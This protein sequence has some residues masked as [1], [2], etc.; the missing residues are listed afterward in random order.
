MLREKHLKNSPLGRALALL[1]NI[2]LGSKGLSWT[3]TSEKK[4]NNQCRQ[5]DETCFFVI[6]ATAK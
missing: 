2:K 1:A 5:Y 3:N 4:F 6:D